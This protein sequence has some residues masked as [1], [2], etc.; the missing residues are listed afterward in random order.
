VSR[1]GSVRIGYAVPTQHLLHRVA[2]SDALR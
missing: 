1:T 2:T